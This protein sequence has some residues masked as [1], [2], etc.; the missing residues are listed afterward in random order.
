MNGGCKGGCDE[1]KAIKNR[2]KNKRKKS[3]LLMK[4]LIILVNRIDHGIY[5]MLRQ[6]IDE[7]FY[8][9]QNCL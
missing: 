8:V 1:K 4:I 6:S 5:E 3:R 2:K 9:H 7:K